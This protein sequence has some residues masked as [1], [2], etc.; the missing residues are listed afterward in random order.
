MN[1]AT[2]RVR[3]LD[4]TLRDGSHGIG[5]RYRTACDCRGDNC[6]GQQPVLRREDPLGQ[7]VR[8]IAR[9]DR[10]SSLGQYGPDKI[11][12]RAAPPP[13][14]KNHPQMMATTVH[15]PLRGVAALLPGFG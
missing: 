11:R 14:G 8:G 4:S 3:L 13:A 7:S 10:H 1:A 5:H 2:P 15:Q 9:Q 6:G 12:A